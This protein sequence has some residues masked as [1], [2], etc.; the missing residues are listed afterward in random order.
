MNIKKLGATSALVIA[1]M[2][3][4]A[5]GAYAAPTDTAAP[6][7]NSAESAQR[8]INYEVSRSGDDVLITTDAGT[9]TTSDTQLE[10]RDGS[11]AVVAGVPLTYV[12]N[13][14]AFPIAASVDGNTARLTPSRTP[15]ARPDLPLRDVD[16]STAVTTAMPELALA[17]SAGAILGAVVGGGGGCI[18]G[19]VVG[20]AATA[21]M[22]ALL[23]AGPLAGCAMGAVTMAPLGAIGGSI[24]VGGP[25]L[26]AVAIQFVQL[27]G[28]PPAPK[29]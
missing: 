10:V 18:A 5:G 19:A 7:S 11:G 12:M 28:Q 25:A 16:L 13:D 15:V 23:G 4:T 29:K 22:A 17:A 3:V 8:V 14:K 26:L 2:T 24:L 9:L 6:S 21:P 1:A 27:L 20:L